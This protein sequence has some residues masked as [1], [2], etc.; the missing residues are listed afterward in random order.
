M[1][2]RTAVSVQGESSYLIACVREEKRL[3]YS[4]TRSIKRRKYECLHVNC[5]CDSDTTIVDITIVVVNT[6]PSVVIEPLYYAAHVEMSWGRTSEHQTAPDLPR[7]GYRGGGDRESRHSVGAINYYSN[8]SRI[9]VIERRKMFEQTDSAYAADRSSGHGSSGHRRATTGSRLAT[10][11]DVSRSSSFRNSKRVKIDDGSPVM[12]NKQI[13]LNNILPLW[14]RLRNFGHYDIQ[15][16]TLEKLAITSSTGTPEHN[17]KRPTGASAAL[18]Q[19]SATED[20]SNALIA[21][22]PAFRNEIGGDFDHLSHDLMTFRESLSHD[23]QKRIGSREKILLDGEVP[24]KEVVQN[25]GP[26]SL[27]ITEVLQMQ[28]GMNFPFEYID[29]GASYYRN[30]FLGQG[31]L[32]VSVCVCFCLCCYMGCIVCSCGGLVLGGLYLENLME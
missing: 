15:S 8:N 18:A 20:V 9:P 2:Y 27:A 10:R 11:K 14:Q 32:L 31:E 3:S 4:R 26:M 7:R 28:T 12:R 30:Y 29:Y 24:L 1:P 22:C 6:T 21:T 19:E 23:K 17:V 13:G 25:R 16:L 5:G